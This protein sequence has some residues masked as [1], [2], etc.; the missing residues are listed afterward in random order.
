VDREPTVVSARGSVTLSSNTGTETITLAVA[1]TLGFSLGNL[2]L[3][4]PR[5]VVVIIFVVAGFSIQFRRPCSSGTGT[6][7][8]RT[9]S[10]AVTVALALARALRVLS[11]VMIEVYEVTPGRIS[12]RRYRSV[13]HSFGVG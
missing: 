8:T 3:G 7:H 5:L 6:R 11:L 9:R 4:S 1:G 2:S 13:F 12:A 10:V